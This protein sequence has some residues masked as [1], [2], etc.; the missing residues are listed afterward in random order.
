MGLYK[1]P[2]QSDELYHFGVKGMKWGVRRYQNKDGSLTAAGKKRYG[3]KEN[4][5][6]HKEVSKAN[7]RAGLITAA[8]VAAG[9]GAVAG[10]VKAL[11][12]QSL[13]RNIRQGKGKENTSPAESITKNVSSS[14]D[15]ADKGLSAYADMRTRNRQKVTNPALER[16]IK[17]MSNKELQ[18]RI[19]RINLE[20]RYRDLNTEDFNEGI[21]TAKDVLAVVGSVAA[22]AYAVTSIAAT[23]YKM[24]KGSL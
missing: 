11:G 12:S 23:V 21:D 15:A 18:D 5:E 22:T 3:S 13:D 6:Y 10:G 1:T 9:A 16:E 7:R 2:V 14:I 17:S 8:G 24:K 19:N 20:Q 4:L